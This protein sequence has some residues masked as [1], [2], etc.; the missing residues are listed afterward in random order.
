MKQIKAFLFVSILISMQTAFSAPPQNLKDVYEDDV[1]LV[2]EN[3][4]ED[5]SETIDDGESSEQENFS[6]SEESETD[7]EEIQ[8]ED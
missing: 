1:E 3:Q 4:G 5:S 2:E 7:S 6:D 8:F